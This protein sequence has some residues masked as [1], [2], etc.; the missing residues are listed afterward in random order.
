M[1]GAT[2]ADTVRRMRR[3]RFTA[4]L[5][6]SLLVIAGG[7]GAAAAQQ[8]AKARVAWLTVAA[9][10]M[11]EPF[12]E[13]LRNLGYVEGKSIEIIY[14]HASGRADRLPELAAALVQEN[15]DVIVVSGSA[16]MHAA[17]R[18]IK[19][20]PV[21]FVASDPVG[22]GVIASLGRPGG[23]LTGLA[24]PFAET[25]VK[26]LELVGE[27]LPG[28][29]RMAVLTDRAGEHRAGAPGQFEAMQ[30]AAAPLGKQLL[31]LEITDR[32][33]F[34]DMFAAARR[35]GADAMIV[36]SS[37]LFATHRV[38]IVASAARHRMP[39]VYEHRAF[40]EVGGLVSYG[41][42]LS[43]VF[44]RAANYVDRIL[45]GAKPADLPVEQPSTFETVVN[46]KTARALGLPISNAL[47]SRADEVID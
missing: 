36:V 41:P 2:I 16:T 19:V 6:A 31:R 10:P 46:L 8:P 34:D 5:V 33:E 7:I 9:H 32:L 3:R 1:L 27:L 22:Q 21:V 39:T 26:W 30:I 25:S 20:I 47:L 4:A 35:A 12:R 29:T 23:N 28:T 40:A 37:P 18:M 15:P 38:E 11:I 45:K 44:R 13:G 24:L 43:D 17:Y 42:D 14:R